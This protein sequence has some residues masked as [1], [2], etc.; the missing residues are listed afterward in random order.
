MEKARFVYDVDHIALPLL[1]LPL[2]VRKIHLLH[3]CT[4]G[5]LVAQAGIQALNI[6]PPIEG[7]S[8]VLSDQHLINADNLDYE[9]YTLSKS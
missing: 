7:A 3:H 9:Q 1:K 5:L 6:S 8:S 4:N 2:V